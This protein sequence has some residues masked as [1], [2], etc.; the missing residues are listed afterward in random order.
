MSSFTYNSL[1][2]NHKEIRILE[3]LPAVYLREPIQ[4][5]IFKTPLDNLPSFSAL[6]YTWGDG[7]TRADISLGGQKLSITASLATALKA[8]RAADHSVLL[9]IDQI[10]INQHNAE[11]KSRQIPL[12]RSIYSLSAQTI[13]WLGEST[14]DSDLAMDYLQDVGS[15]ARALGLANLEATQLQALLADE[16]DIVPGMIAMEESTAEMRRSVYDLISNQGSLLELPAIEGMIQLYMLPYFQRGWIQQEV[17]IPRTLV[18]KW[19]DKT[20]RAEVFA[21]GINFYIIYVA[22]S[23]PTLITPSIFAMPLARALLERV[24]SVN[25]TNHIRPTLVMRDWYHSPK[26]S[27]L[28]MATL[29]ERLRGVKFSQPGDK[30][31]GIL[32]LAADIGNLKLE[33]DV[34]RTWEDIFTHA[35]KRIVNTTAAGEQSRGG[36]NFLSLVSFPKASKALPSW[37]PDF[38][39]LDNVNTLRSN[40]ITLSP[41]YHASGRMIH[42]MSCDDQDLFGPEVLRWRGVVV[43]RIIEVGLEWEVDSSGQHSPSAGLGPLSSVAEFVAMSAAIVTSD[44]FSKHPFRGQ[45]QRLV[46]AE[47][48]VPVLGRESVSSTSASRRAEQRSQKGHEMV[49]YTMVFDREWPDVYKALASILITPQEEVELSPM[50]LSYEDRQL[51]EVKMRMEKNNAFKKSPEHSTYDLLMD[52]FKER[53]SFLGAEGFVGVGPLGVQAGD[54]ICVFYG[55]SFPYVL[56]EVETGGTWGTYKLVGEAYCDGIMDDEALTMGIADQEF[57]LV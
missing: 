53:R 21:A 10:Y 38:T 25:M 37:V 27:T 35:T 20:I 50:H 49:K 1:P 56:R 41:P 2:L 11:E 13:G 55:G 43:D 52:A 16:A 26:R 46:E 19:G 44:P 40:T 17:A 24:R 6:S 15:R 33:V 42:T 23:V 34:A 14:A 28:T 9:W 31:H 57:R 8:L 47:W 18:L 54:V 51:A 39:S 12:M 32:G 3:L 7:S 48:R 29:M 22:K 36:I 30:I 4:A 45:P 5:R